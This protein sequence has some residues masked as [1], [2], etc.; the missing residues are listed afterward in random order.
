MMSS[1]PSVRVVEAVA[2]K[3]GV[4]SVEL[5]PPLMTVID[6]D[7]L[8]ALVR[9]GAVSTTKPIEIEFTYQGYLVRVQN[10]PTVAVTVR[11]AAEPESTTAADAPPEPRSGAEE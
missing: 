10:D 8:D 11:D 9:S 2:R 6:P 1:L 4:P 5:S 7:A 3:E